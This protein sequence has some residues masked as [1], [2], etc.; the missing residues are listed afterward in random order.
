MMRTGGF[1]EP[2]GKGKQ[3][4][5]ETDFETA[6]RET[7]EECSL[8][9][10]DLTF[11]FGK[12]SFETEKYK[13]NKKFVIYYIAETKVE[14]INIPFN[15]QIGKKEHDAYYWMTYDEANKVAVPRI[16]AVLKWANGLIKQ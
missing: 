6:L 8:N 11:P 7:E 13:K 3:E 10:K 15:P 9:I 14:Q 1:F 5:S 2:G 4:S 16:Q 12:V